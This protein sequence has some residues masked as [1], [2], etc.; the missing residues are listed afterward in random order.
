MEANFRSAG[1]VELWFCF[2]LLKNSIHKTVFLQEL[3]QSKRKVKLLR[4]SKVTVVRVFTG[5]LNKDTNVFPF[6]TI[7]TEMKVV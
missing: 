1:F 3:Y 5:N 6:Q 7:F 4:Q 2:V